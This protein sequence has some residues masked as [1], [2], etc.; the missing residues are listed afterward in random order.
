MLKDKITIMVVP[1]KGGDMSSYSIPVKLLWAV[2]LFGICFIAINVF[3]LSDYFSQRVDRARLDK[4]LR[5][6]QMLSEQYTAMEGSIDD[7]QGSYAELVNK[8]E[9][10]RTIFGLPEINEE[11]RMLGVGGPED[12]ALNNFT[13][14]T[15]EALKVSADVDE[16]LRLAKFERE[17]YRDVYELLGN[18]RD[19]LNHTP[20]IKP[21]RGYPSSGYG[22]R[23]DPFTGL[24]EFHPGLDISN[25]NG[26]PIYA[27]AEGKIT[28]VRINGGLGKMVSIDHG[29]GFITRYGH[30]SDYKVK[31]G[32]RVKRGDIIGLMGSTGYTT[33]PHLHYEVIKKGKHVNP[34][35]Y[36]INK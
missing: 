15:A 4:L 13:E 11:A 24:K 20:S 36:I 17:R 19:L 9:A 35:K 18:K 6:N 28:A 7:L 33:G 21:A 1:R 8:E 25:S 32:Q 10:I 5:E 12:P 14:A 30:L 34:Y 16:L 3:L 2:A 22:T 31:V 26:T 23:N 27:T 29:Y